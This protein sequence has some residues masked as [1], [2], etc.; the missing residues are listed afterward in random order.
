MPNQKNSQ[1][2]EVL[3]EKLSKANS[4][5][6]TD[7][8]GLSAEEM[9]ILR[10]K[11]YE[12]GIEYRVVKN[13]LVAYTAKKLGYEG[14]EEILKGPTAVALGYEDP[15]AAARVI[16]DFLKSVGKAKEKP[17]VKGMIFDGDV[18]D[19]SRFDAIANL[20]TKEELLA[21]LLSGLQSPMQGVMSV[22]QAPMRDLVG[23][24]VSLKE[25]KN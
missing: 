4:A 15:T 14:L 3:E 25:S 16:K 12:A 2:V 11:F 20:P 10:S 8:M 6:F 1:M 21:K 9:N 5:F 7:Y 18:L 17:A 24:L 23:V 13:T 19:A 22:L